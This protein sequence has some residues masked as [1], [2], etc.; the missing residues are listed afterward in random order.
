MFQLDDQFL[1]DV[2]LGDMPDDA[3]PAQEATAE[4][5]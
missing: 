4:K 2:G 1:Q 5:P 3:K